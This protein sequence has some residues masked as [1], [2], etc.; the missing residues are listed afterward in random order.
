MTTQSINEV[1]VYHDETK[2]VA[3]GKFKGHV[4]FFVPMRVECF[5]ETPLFGKSKFEYS[6]RNMLYRKIMELRDEYHIQKKLHF[7]DI[8]G[9]KWGKY[10]LGT[11]QIVCASIDALKH[12]FSNT[13]KR[14][15]CCKLAI[16]FYPGSVDLSLYGGDE[17]KERNFRYDET[18]L[19]M[20]LKGAAHYLYQNDEQVVVKKIVS[21]G[22]PNH[23]Q[24]DDDRIM[25]RITYDDW[26][27][28]TPLRDYVRF[29]SDAE[30]IHLQSD[31]K[32]YELDTPEYIDA[33]ML[34]IADLLLGAVKRACY[35][36]IECVEKVP[37]LGSRKYSK[38]DVI[39]YPAKKMLDKTKRGK[40]FK[41]SGHYRSFSISRVSFTDGRVSFSNLHPKKVETDI[42]ANISFLD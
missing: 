1:I 29:A 7:T 17:K 9:R 33:N 3:R 11:R 27:G 34:Q 6:S 19:R 41:N 13:F 42:D 18:N 20:L 37:R 31:H 36:G 22:D 24:L 10:D 15:L 25:W 39:A 16:I 38:K 4:L 26:L 35:A 8:S 2:Y 21:D 40:G 23:R 14:P 28:K 12:N 5:H 32:L 30:I